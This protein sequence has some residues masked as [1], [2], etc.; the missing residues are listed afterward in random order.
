M[1]SIDLLLI[2]RA[3]FRANTETAENKMTYIS[4][5]FFSNRPN[6]NM[7]KINGY[8]IQTVNIKT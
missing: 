1:G 4:V 3:K 5:L 8:Q 6:I 2:V 7:N